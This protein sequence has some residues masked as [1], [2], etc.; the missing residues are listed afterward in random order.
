MLDE[1]LG[2]VISE[3]EFRCSASADNPAHASIVG[4]HKI[5]FR[6]ED[7]IIEVTAESAIR[8]TGNEFH[9]SINLHVTRNGVL[10]FQ[11][12][13]LRTEPRLLL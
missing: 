13:W 10:F 8:A 4:I 5:A 1:Q 3:S 7:G 11:K 6:R 2:S 12:H 9:I